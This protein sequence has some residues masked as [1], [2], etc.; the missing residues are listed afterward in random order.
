M[1]IECGYGKDAVNTAHL[2]RQSPAVLVVKR[3]CDDHIRGAAS[4][5]GF[6]V[7]TNNYYPQG[8]APLLQG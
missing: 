8:V 1:G 2:S 6:S 5:W 3:D 4:D 7:A